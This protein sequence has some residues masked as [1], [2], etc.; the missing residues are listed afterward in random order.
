MSTAVEYVIYGVQAEKDL[1]DWLGLALTSIPAFIA[2]WFTWSQNNATRTHNKLS[3]T[4]HLDSMTHTTMLDDA[5]TYKY[6]ITNNGVG[7]AILKEAT[8]TVD[9]VEIDTDETIPDVVRALLPGIKDDQFSHQSVAI[10]SFIS[11]GTTIDIV[12]IPCGSKNVLEEVKMKAKNRANIL[13]HY[14]SIYGEKKTFNS[15]HN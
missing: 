9:G 3:V 7:P 12:T 14:E 13:L 1:T 4:P 5:F 11:A 10:G 15:E 6:S 2:L 8:F